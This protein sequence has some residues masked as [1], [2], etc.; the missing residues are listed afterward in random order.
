M[1]C[2]ARVAKPGGRPIENRA[3]PIVRRGG[4]TRRLVRFLLFVAAALI[5]VDALVGNRGL[6]AM[7]D[8]RR[9]HAELAA[10]IARQRAENARLREE[11]RRLTHDPSAIEEIARRDLGLI[12]PGEKVF[13][14]KDLPTPA[15]P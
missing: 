9:Q 1:Y 13:I 5:V 2:V 7:L 12:R 15:A 6:L 14:V 10:A 3:S 8:A 11:A 4:R